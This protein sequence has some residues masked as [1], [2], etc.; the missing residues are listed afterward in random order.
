M[1]A[2]FFMIAVCIYLLFC[3]A[4]LFKADNKLVSF[5]IASAMIWALIALGMMLGIVH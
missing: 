3:A 2:L 1:F 4:A 5:W